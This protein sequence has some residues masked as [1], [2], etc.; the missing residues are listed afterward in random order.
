MTSEPYC[1]RRWGRGDGARGD[2]TDCRHAGSPLDEGSRFCYCAC[3][4]YMLQ[5][6]E[7]WTRRESQYI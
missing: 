5:E 7:V 4:A 1:G 6:Q 2:I 3:R